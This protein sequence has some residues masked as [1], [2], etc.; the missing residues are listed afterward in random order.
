MNHFK[1]EFSF[2]YFTERILLGLPLSRIQLLTQVDH[3][4]NEKLLSSQEKK[5]QSALKIFRS[6]GIL[7]FYKGWSAHLACS[8]Q[9]EISPYFSKF[10]EYSLISLGLDPYLA[11]LG[12]SAFTSFCLYPLK[13][14]Y[15]EICLDVKDLDS[16]RNYR[17]LAHCIQKN[18][19]NGGIL[20][21]YS[22]AKWYFFGEIL[23]FLANFYSRKLFEKLEISEINKEILDCYVDFF[24]SFVIYPIETLVYREVAGRFI[25]DSERMYFFREKRMEGLYNGFCFFYHGLKRIKGVE[26]C[27]NPLGN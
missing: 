7:G 4:T 10:W 22:G 13:F 6:E 26:Y 25:R 3:F 23:K 11:Q 15:L 16:N 5:A 24:M 9:E 21:F 2:N 1:I 27:D 8:I 12:A 18:F 17:G 20:N 19:K 14:C